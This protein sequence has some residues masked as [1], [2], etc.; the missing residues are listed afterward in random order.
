M[1]NTATVVAFALGI[2]VM[3]FY[4]TQTESGWTLIYNNV[5]DNVAETEE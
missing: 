3:Y 1:F 4:C 5:S 2:L